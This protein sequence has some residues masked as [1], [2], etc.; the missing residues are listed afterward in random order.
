MRNRVTPDRLRQFGPRALFHVTG[1]LDLVLH[2]DEISGGVHLTSYPAR[3][4]QLA[5]KQSGD[6]VGIV[7]LDRYAL[8]TDLTSEGDVEAIYP[9]SQYA[10]G[11][12]RWGD[13]AAPFAGQRFSLQFF[14]QSEAMQR[15]YGDRRVPRED[16]EPFG[17]LTA[18][19]AAHFR[20]RYDE[21]TFVERAYDAL[22]ANWRS[23]SQ[24]LE[25]F[26]G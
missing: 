13:Q 9:L 10:I 26:E 4:V 24:A 12:F 5:A 21:A 15:H 8:Q 17:E 23:A 18:A 20:A 6:S 25:Q 3:A 11:F 19:M 14:C 22:L 2:E 16:I 7:V 1:S